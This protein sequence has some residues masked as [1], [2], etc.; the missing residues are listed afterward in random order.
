MM[1]EGINIE[2]LQYSTIVP[3]V[4]SLKRIHKNILF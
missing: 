1:M 2:A 3:T 4:E